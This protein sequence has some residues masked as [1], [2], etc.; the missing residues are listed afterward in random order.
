MAKG[1]TGIALNRISPTVGMNGEA[2]VL[3]WF[4]DVHA[5]IMHM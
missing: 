2:F 5:C 3:H 1:Y 4:I